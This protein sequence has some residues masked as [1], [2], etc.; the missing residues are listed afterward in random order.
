MAGRFSLAFALTLSGCAAVGDDSLVDNPVYEAA[1]PPGWWVVIG[2]DIALRLGHEFFG[3]EIWSVVYRYP[4][5]PARTSRDVRR[6]RSHS[7][8]SVIV[9][10][11]RRGPCTSPGG[12]VY[13]DNVRVV[14]GPRDLA[15]CG[16]RPVGGGRP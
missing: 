5:V 1:G 11:A 2:D 10:E 7:A 12:S 9:V 13:Q 3:G 14:T 4:G 15:G 16:G 8:G 6:W